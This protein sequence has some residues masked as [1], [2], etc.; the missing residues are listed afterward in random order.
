MHIVHLSTEFAP[1]AK[2]GGLGDVTVG[3]CREL[4]RMGH[5]VSVFIPRYSFIQAPLA[6][7][8]EPFPCLER[9]TSHMNTMFSASIENCQVF[10]LDT[11]HPKHY[12]QREHIYGYPD[13]VARFL[14]FT[15]AVLEFLQRQNQ[16]IDILHLHDWPVAIAALLAKKIFHSPIKKIVLTIHNA[17]YQGLCA[18]SDLDALGLHGSNYLTQDELQDDGSH[19][20]NLLK[21]GIVYADAVNTVSPSYAKEIL[22]PHF[23]KDLHVTLNRYQ[24]KISGILNGIDPHLWNPMLDRYLPK[25]YHAQQSVEEILAAK[26][27]AKDFLRKRFNLHENHLPWIGAV[28]RIVHQKNPHLLEVGFKYALKNGCNFL[29]L[30]SSPDP[31]IQEHFNKL[32]NEY[33]HNSSVLLHFAYDD[34]LAHQIFAALDFLF[35]PSLYEPCG[36]TQ[37]IGMRYGTLPIVHATGGL[38]DTVFDYDNAKIPKKIRNGIL[39]QN[40]NSSDADIAIQRAI[41]LFRNYPK[42]YQSLMTQIMQLKFD[43][44]KP[45][46]S[47]LDLY[48]KTLT[49]RELRHG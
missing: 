35:I 16:P 10:L 5:Q 31:S 20:I 28:T 15:K 23:S 2:A 3:L 40:I 34:E 12:F 14:Y 8:G 39:F 1:I 47:Y 30:G 42:Q 49:E 17:A 29:L 41:N 38:K 37:L 45:A 19:H 9:G 18:P 44:T 7:E 43:W 33:A 11:H 32:K 21:G 6:Q 26:K 25:P 22:D 27:A 48:E 13:D 4:T 36:L 24:S 46:K